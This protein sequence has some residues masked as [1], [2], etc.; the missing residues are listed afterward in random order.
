MLGDPAAAQD[1]AAAG[2]SS[3]YGAMRA[4]LE[5]SPLGVP[6]VVTSSED[7]EQVRGEVHAL[8]PMPFEDLSARLSV[9]RDWCQIVLLHLNVK[10]CTHERAASQDWLT[11][12]SGR[13]T[14]ENVGKTYPLRFAFRATRAGTDQLDIDL[15]AATGPMGTRDYRL[16]L[17]AVAVPQGSFL[18]FSYAYRSSTLSRLAVGTY[19]ATI[20]RDKVG[21]TVVGKGRD[22][23]PEYVGGDRGIVERNAVR[24]YFA[25]Q[26]YL[27]GF[28]VPGAQRVER[29]LGRW[30]E[31]TERYPTQLRELERSEYLR[32]KLKDFDEQSRRQRALDA[33]GAGAGA[34]PAPAQ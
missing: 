7:G 27:E 17:A 8:L 18:R 13:K 11:V 9:P 33:A 23:Q 28:A 24:Y 2:L 15:S 29:N 10:A 4:Q 20:G 5:A 26:A 21:F 1:S 6:V 12:H 14:H 30:F 25:I 19:L 31:L 32:G 16:A 34:V 3:R 22:G